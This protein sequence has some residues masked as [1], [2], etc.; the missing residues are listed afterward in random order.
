[1]SFIASRAASLGFSVVRAP[2][3]PV[4]V[5]VRVVSELRRSGEETK[6]LRLEIETMRKRLADL[7]RRAKR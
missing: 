3:T 7:E 4:R 1:V 6:E 5:V 2:I